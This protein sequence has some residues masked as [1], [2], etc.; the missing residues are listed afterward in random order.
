MT[1]VFNSILIYMILLSGLISCKI[2]INEPLQDF[3]F[4]KEET[5]SCGEQT[6]K[7]KIYRHDLTGLQF[8]L[9]PGKGEIKPFLICQ[10]EV[11]QAVWKKIMN[12]SPWAELGVTSSLRGLP[13]WREGPNY[14]ASYLSWDDCFSF[15]GKTGLRFPTEAEWEYACNGGAQTHFCFGD[16]DTKL[17]GYAWFEKNTRSVGENFP[18]KVKNK[19]PNAFGLYDVHGNVSEWCENLHQQEHTCEWCNET[20]KGEAPL[21]VVK[22]GAWYYPAMLCSTARHEAYHPASYFREL[23]FRPACSVQTPK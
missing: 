17:H 20:F 3:T 14:P 22:G 23:G 6:N 13:P 7:I 5:Y 2:K 21:R 15:C 10:T 8:S 11:T 16:S 1:K 4:L 18:H 12:I 9:I 19:K